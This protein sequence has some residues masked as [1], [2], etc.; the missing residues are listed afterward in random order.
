MT[1]IGRIFQLLK[2]AWPF[3]NVKTLVVKDIEVKEYASGSLERLVDSLA[4]SKDYP[5]VVEELILHHSHI[6]GIESGA[7]ARID[8]TKVKTCRILECNIDNFDPCRYQP[9]LIYQLKDVNRFG[10]LTNLTRLDIQNSRDGNGW[11]KENLHLLKANPNLV[12]LTIETIFQWHNRTEGVQD[13]IVAMPNLRT[14]L[15][16]FSDD[17]FYPRDLDKLVCACPLIKVYG[18]RFNDLGEL[19]VPQNLFCVRTS[20][21]A[22]LTSRRKLVSGKICVSLRSGCLL[23]PRG[24]TLLLK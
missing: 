3:R 15:V 8:M 22:L 18:H 4:Y 16:R 14:L 9:T 21:S 11:E 19:A 2:L 7:L 1:P 17:D 13:A 6:F 24:A 10:L 5:L 23:S 12:E 20:S